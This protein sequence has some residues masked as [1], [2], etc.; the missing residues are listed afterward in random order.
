MHHLCES[1]PEKCGKSILKNAYMNICKM[2]HHLLVVDL[3]PT[4]FETDDPPENHLTYKVC[5]FDDAY[6]I[7]ILREFGEEALP[8]L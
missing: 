2:N 4:Q 8:L 1:P 7:C 3:W 6:S 5:A